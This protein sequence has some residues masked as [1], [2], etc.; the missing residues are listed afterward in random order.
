MEIAASYSQKSGKITAPDG[1]A[2]AAGW[3]GHGAGKNNPAMQDRVAL[4]PLPQGI[5]VVGPWHDHPRLGRMVAELTQI[6]GE[7]FGRSAF[8]IHGASRD[9]K[10]FGEESLGCIVVPYL[11]RLKAK[12][13]LPEGSYLKVTP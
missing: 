4:G 12:D 9:A 10:R 5:Y 1:R 2:I 6:E 13:T 8:F 11:G 3:A 7:T